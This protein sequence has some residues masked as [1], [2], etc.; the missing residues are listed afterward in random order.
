MSK[1][2]Q[3]VMGITET[4]I[5]MLDILIR[6]AK[7]RDGIVELEDLEHIRSELIRMSGKDEIAEAISN[8]S[9]EVKDGS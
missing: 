4:K 9:E 1:L 2:L 6:F 3:N 7:K 8:F 5:S